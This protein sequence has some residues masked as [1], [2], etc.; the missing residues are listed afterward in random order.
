MLSKMGWKEGQGLGKD[1][2]GVIPPLS[3]FSRQSTLGLGASD[4][5]DGVTSVPARD[6]LDKILQS[7]KSTGEE[8][9]SKKD[10]KKRRKNKSS[11]RES[12][13]AVVPP[14][15]LF[16]HRQRFICNK[17]V[18]TYSDSQLREILGDNFS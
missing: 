6:T 18:S 3:A 14:P 11:K 4:D 10:G 7:L 13:S 9:P 8:I 1:A 17:N 15:V 2:D 16:A 5:Q 12:N